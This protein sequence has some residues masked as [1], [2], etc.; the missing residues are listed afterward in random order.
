VTQQELST[1]A[2]VG[3]IKIEMPQRNKG[4]NS[5]MVPE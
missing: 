1:D 3:N 5:G 4:T 2:K